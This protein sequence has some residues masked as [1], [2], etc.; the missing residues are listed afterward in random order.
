MKRIEV[1]VQTGERQEI[2]LTPEEI[3]A[4]PGAVFSQAAALQRL[5][6]W[7]APN[8]DK[9]LFLAVDLMA[10]GNQ[11]DAAKVRAARQIL[12]DMPT[13][14]AL[15][16]CTSDAAFDYVAHE[17][18]KEARNLLPLALQQRFVQVEG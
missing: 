2:D 16:A 12:Q 14:P 5:R 1:N 18:W 17:R 10:E 13:Y 9:L 4:L 3:A 15:L 7:R 6:V 11:T 8:L